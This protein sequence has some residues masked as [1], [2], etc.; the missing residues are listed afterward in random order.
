M[1]GAEG[2]FDKISFQF[3]VVIFVLFKLINL[4]FVGEIYEN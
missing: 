4:K 1:L 2:K 3:L